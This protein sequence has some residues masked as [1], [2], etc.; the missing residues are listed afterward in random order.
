MILIEAI[1]LTKFLLLPIITGI[2]F[3][4]FAWASKSLKY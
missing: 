2:G 1:F 3:V 4:I